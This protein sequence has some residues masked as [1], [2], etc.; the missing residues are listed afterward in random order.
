MKVTDVT[1]RKS[2]ED[3]DLE[4]LVSVTFNDYFV[5]H[6]I[7][8]IKEKNNYYIEMPKH[9]RSDGQL[10]N[11]ASPANPMVMQEI[12]KGI[13]QAYKESALNEDSMAKQD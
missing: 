6:D 11:I 10:V 3:S 4:A 5:V 9:K 2:F 7:K 8:I 1:I 12:T 13:I